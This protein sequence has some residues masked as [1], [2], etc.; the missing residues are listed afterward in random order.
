MN[1]AFVEIQNFRK[2]KSCRI[3]FNDT[4][5]V[6][7]GANNSGKTSAMLALKKFLKT[8]KI[9]LEDFTISNWSIINHIGEKYIINA[10]TEPI[11]IG[12]WVHILPA[13][14]VWLD[15]RSDEIRYVQISFRHWNGTVGK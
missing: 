6:F 4:S 1:I 5:T 8:E 15:V 10:E 9:I 11:S 7:V 3:D 13:M 14:D 2:L 12:D